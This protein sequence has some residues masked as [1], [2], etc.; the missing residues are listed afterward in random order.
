MWITDLDI[1]TAFLHS[2]LKED[3]DQP[4]GFEKSKGLDLIGK[5]RKRIYGLKQVA[6]AWNEKINQMLVMAGFV[7]AD[8]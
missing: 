1:K 6:R 5:P 2:D 8:P 4:T 3:M 7:K